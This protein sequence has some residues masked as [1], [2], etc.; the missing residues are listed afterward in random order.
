[1][2]GAHAGVVEAGRD[3]VGVKDLA[4]VILKDVRA[5]AVKHS[6]GALAEGRGVALGVEAL[7]GGFD[8]DQADR[9]IRH[10][11]VEDAHGV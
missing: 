6:H 5:A 9:S 11:A 10:E 2:F 8:A 7:A 4:L 3:R 1:M